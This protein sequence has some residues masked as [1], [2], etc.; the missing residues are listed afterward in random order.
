MAMPIPRKL[1][2]LVTL[3]ALYLTGCASNPPTGPVYDPFEN[4]NRKIYSFNDAVDK[5]VLK[6]VARGYRFILPDFVEVGI[7]NFFSNLD[8]INVI[9]NGLLQ[10]KFKQAGSDTGRFLYNTTAGLLGFI[11]VSTRAGMVKHNESFGQTLGV[12]GIGEG[13][14]L[15]LPFLGP[16]NGRSTTGLVVE[17]FTTNVDPYITDNSDALIGLTALELVAL[18]ARLLSASQFLDNALDPY[19]TL[20]DF[21]VQQHRTATWEGT[22]EVRIGTADDDGFDD[23][24]DEL[25]ELDELDR[26]DADDDLDELDELDRLDALEQRSKNSDELDELDRLDA[27]DQQTSQPDELDELDRLDAQDSLTD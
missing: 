5:A 9:A 1:S 18:R 3:L 6:P 4:V 15:M 7:N 20:R 8:D 24:L 19:Q 21:W 12:W 2:L 13:P 14:Y 25:D 22:R 17:T 16:A 11:D 26:L 23:D 27:L 10:G